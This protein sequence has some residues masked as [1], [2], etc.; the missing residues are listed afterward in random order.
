M[1]IEVDSD[2][3]WEVREKDSSPCCSNRTLT[4]DLLRAPTSSTTTD[5]KPSS[6][7]QKNMPGNTERAKNRL[8]EFISRWTR[9]LTPDA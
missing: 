1:H 5:G 7:G 3:K 2:F 6:S 8:T 9:L 4:G